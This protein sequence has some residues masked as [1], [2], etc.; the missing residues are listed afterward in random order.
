MIESFKIISQELKRAIRINTYLPSDYYNNSNKYNAILM[1]DGQLF[2]NEIYKHAKYDLDIK[3]EEC[4]LN[5]I[6]IGISFPDD[7]KWRLSELVEYNLGDGYDNKLSLK[8]QE[9][10]INNLI[11]LLKIKYRLN[12]NLS[13]FSFYESCILGINLIYNF[14]NLAYFS[15]KLLNF[16]DELK[17][18][19]ENIKEKNIYIYTGAN[20]AKIINSSLILNRVLEKNKNINYLL[21]YKENK[22]NDII[23]I[24]EHIIFA[25]KFLQE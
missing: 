2:F 25:D 7:E 21:D 18:K 22:N 1:L 20:D 9:Y 10:F 24:M 6:V 14:K 4:E 5:N 23:D 12:N 17:N 8:F 11:P 3:L 16:D 19:F 13:L 15:P